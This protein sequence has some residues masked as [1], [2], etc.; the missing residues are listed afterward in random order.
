MAD[1]SA[2]LPSAAEKVRRVPP[3]VVV[4]AAA[5]AVLTGD[6]V[7]GGASNKYAP[8]AVIGVILGAVVIRLAK[9][10]SWLVASMLVVIVLIPNDGRYILAAHLP[11]QI[12]PYRL[13]V[14]LIVVGWIIA[15]LVDPRVRARATKLD[16]PI[17]LIIVATL[18]SEIA[19]PGR[20]GALSS[21]VIKSMWLF[22]TL[23]FLFYLMV[24]V[25]RNRAVI[26]RLLTVLVVCGGIEALGAIY[27]RRSGN[28]IFDS[29]H[30]LLPGFTFTGLSGAAQQ[31]RGGFIRATA[32]AG[33]PIELSSTMAMMLPLAVYLAISRRQR[34]WWLVALVLIGGDFAGGSR[35]GII[36]LLVIVATFVC[37]RPRQTLR[38]WPALFPA[39]IAVHFVAPGA[40][41]GIQAGFFPSG[42][43]VAQQSHVFIAR[44]GVAEDNTRLS[45]WGPSFQEWLQ[46]N[47]LF[48]EGFGT[49][50]TGVLA[51]G[52]TNPDDNATVLDNE[53]LGTL[54]E[55]GLV[56]VIAWIWLFARVIRRLGA[57]AKLERGT[58]EGW[59]PVALAAS[60]GS[61]AASMFFY[62]AFSFIQATCVMFALLAI[63]SVVL[64]LPPTRR[65]AAA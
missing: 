56:G 11:I 25:V 61:F 1:T 62:D 24:S 28:N 12:Q 14:G 32:S 34:R 52:R 41:G 58:S 21:Y 60:I 44:G 63:A 35:T 51:N 13:V 15:L 19:N 3:A 55:T 38:C 64:L 10:W 43:L 29:I 46:H 65:L 36:S 47:P 31:V 57:R 6:V 5:A 59:L 20:A 9:R 53:W 40:I 39:L 16:A 27:Q 4:I 48:G 42:G 18:G 23:I 50:V 22:A 33:H 7:R 8:L 54:L 17:I 26:E 37:M 30:F 49:R 45:R 2:T